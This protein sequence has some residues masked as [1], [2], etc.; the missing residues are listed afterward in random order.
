M[1][2]SSPGV[3][4]VAAGVGAISRWRCRP[5]A[6]SPVRGRG[7]LLHEPP[8]NAGAFTIRSH[9]DWRCST[10]IQALAAATAAAAAAVPDNDDSPRRRQTTMRTWDTAP[11]VEETDRQAWTTTG[12]ELPVV[13]RTT[14]RLRDAKWLT[15][16]WQV[17]RSAHTATL[18]FFFFFCL[19]DGRPLVPPR[20]AAHA[21]RCGVKRRASSAAIAMSYIQTKT[22]PRISERLVHHRPADRAAS[23]FGGGTLRAAAGRESGLLVL[24]R[25]SSH[26]RLDGTEMVVPLLS[27]S[28]SMICSLACRQTLPG[29]V[30]DR[31]RARIGVF[32]AISR[33]CRC[34]VTA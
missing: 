8:P 34:A 15:S 33:P 17:F 24:G 31:N 20:P 19:H 23:S 2:A 18:S 6:A 13:A 11:L 4:A 32:L 25:G 26:S 9:R 3:A 21:Q 7:L 10:G 16:F 27:P 28:G 29:D 14:S 1:T 5:R 22:L 30:R 12:V